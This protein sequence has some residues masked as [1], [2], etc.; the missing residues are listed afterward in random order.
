MQNVLVIKAYL[1]NFYSFYLVLMLLN[2]INKLQLNMK[3][4]Q[5]NKEHKLTSQMGRTRKDHSSV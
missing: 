1:N 5:I 4:M 2:L 3:L